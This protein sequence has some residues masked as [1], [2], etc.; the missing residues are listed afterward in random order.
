MARVC[1]GGFTWRRNTACA[2]GEA[3]NDDLVLRQP[4]ELHSKQQINSRRRGRMMLYV[5]NTRLPLA[6]LR[7][8]IVLP[9]CMLCAQTLL[10]AGS[11]SYSGNVYYVNFITVK[12]G[13]AKKQCAVGS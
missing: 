1:D 12:P 6:L 5:D 7:T 4:I 11:K 10:I 9:F 3:P 8:T 2:G 13:S